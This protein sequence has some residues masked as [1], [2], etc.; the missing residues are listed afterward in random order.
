MQYY[1]CKCGKHEAWNS[2]EALQDCEGC[3]DCKTTY[4]Q[5][6]TGHKPLI[7]HDFKEIVEKR[8]IDGIEQITAH[9]MECQRCHYREKLY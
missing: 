7:P 6:A 8:A 1:K 5:S 2:G 9:Y 4:A 3:E